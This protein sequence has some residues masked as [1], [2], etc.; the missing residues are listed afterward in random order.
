MTGRFTARRVAFTAAA[1]A[2]VGALAFA[3]VAAA[4]GSKAQKG[5]TITV[6]SAGDVDH[7]DPGAA[8]YAF[9]YE[10]TYA[11]QRPLLAYKPNSVQAVPDL[12]ASVPVVSN[13][14]KTVTVHIRHGVKFSP[15][16]NR[17]V[18]S[19]DVKYA[20][21][22][23]FSVSVANGY[24]GSYFGVLVGA[25]TKTP[26]T[27][28]S[29]SGIKT[30]DKYTIVFNLKRP[31]G[32]F[33]ASL[34]LPITAPVPEEYAKS[35]DAKT[36]SDYGNYQVATGPYMIQND[37]SGKLTGYQPNKQIVLVRN[38][39]WNPKTSWRPAYADK[40]VFKE[41]YDDPTV[42]TRQILA[43]QADVNGDTP[44]PAAELRSI[45]SN[46]QQKKQ[47]VFTPTGGSR[48]VAL[49]TS[50][51][52]FNNVNVRKAVAYVLDRNAMRLTRGGP[53]DGRIATHFISPDFKGTGFE[54]SGGFEYNPFPTPNFSGD[55]NKAKQMLKKAG[56]KNGMYSGPQ[57]TM[58]ADSTPPGAD[59]AQVVAADL[60]KIGFNVK[61][62][63][64]THTAMY[65]R[66][67]DVPKQ[68][69]N[70]CP[71]VG[72]LPDFHEPQALLDVTFNG[73]YIVPVNNSNWPLLNDPKV[74]AAADAAEQIMN[75]H[76]RYAA[77][78]K[79]DR[80]VTESAAAIPWLWE[81]SPS[82]YSSRV[83][84]ASELWNEGSPDVTFMKVK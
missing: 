59:T 8:Y 19:A 42:M 4:A 80:M 45:L 53:I 37:S 63:S 17:E 16:V 40:I 47:L 22:R 36:T 32:V 35:H 69:P 83:T 57:V 79:I 61:T 62:I 23:G 38:P 3:A 77:W 49:N 78:A 73:K 9:T 70:I 65:T 6:L 39:N 2:A 25:P 60:A 58:V 13:G 21:E 56:F 46:S 76:A 52:P 15:P 28:P 5:G 84:H 82:I 81:Q 71:N 68:E 66:F 18:T 72:W 33:A 31:S 74:N 7:I 55:V 30:P 12:A 20:I 10:V 51:P 43:G 29:I 14:G 41:G 27:V 75:A 34:S 26:K 64:V 44:P 54:L 24:V 1:L 48:Y 50:K 11:T 67:C